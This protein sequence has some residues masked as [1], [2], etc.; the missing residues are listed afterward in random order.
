[1]K[2]LFVIPHFTLLSAS[3]HRQRLEGLLELLKEHELH[4]LIPD[5]LPMGERNVA[6]IT[7]C[8][9]FKEP[10]LFSLR[11][12]YLIDFCPISLFALRSVIHQEHYSAVVFQFPWGLSLLSHFT[13]V[14]L[15]YSSLGVERDFAP[16]TL[17][18]MGLN[19]FPLSY[20]FRRFVETIEKMA[21]RRAQLILSMSARDSGTYLLDY[22]I[23]AQKLL[24][25]PP[26]AIV[27][28]SAA[29]KSE[30]RR[31]FGL[32]PHK[33]MLLFHGS[34]AHLPNREAINSIEQI[35]APLVCAK[36]PMVQFVVAGQGVPIK[37]QDNIISLGFVD[38]LSELIACADAA[39]VP[40]YQGAGMRMKILDYFR[41]GLP[42]VSTQKGIEGIEIES[43][44]EAIITEDQP[45]AVA[46]AIQQSIKQ[47]NFLAA[48]AANAKRYLQEI[49]NPE[50]LRRKLN[51]KLMGLVQSEKL[52][53]LSKLQTASAGNEP[54]NRLAANE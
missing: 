54:P 48:L 34:A 17:R 53:D 33:R 25:I 18:H 45:Q 12:P 24:S 31:K 5:N 44:R 2:L 27:S 1:M 39:I 11:I 14:P 22:N 28:T 40:I 38:E 46:A 19:F 16:I 37:S 35:I 42:V 20:L 15:V 3:G 8:H 23:P 49:H 51:R 7:R 13:S 41:L 36:D 32:D 29:N 10:K 50:H 43:G 26:P 4:L 30:L 9:F 52:L 47:E 21:C 6:Y